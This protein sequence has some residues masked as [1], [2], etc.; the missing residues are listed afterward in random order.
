MFAKL[1]CLD[2]LLPSLNG[3][4]GEHKASSECGGSPPTRINVADAN[5]LWATF[6]R[7]SLRTFATALKLGISALPSCGCTFLWSPAA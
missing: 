7:D 2:G 4:S 3:G 1:V 6:A 5:T